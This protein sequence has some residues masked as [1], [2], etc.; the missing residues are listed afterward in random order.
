M[1]YRRTGA[2]GQLLPMAE[3][4]EAI[5]TDLV[6]P[7]GMAS[8]QLLMG[9]SHHLLGNQ[10]LARPHLQAALA[11]PASS[12][13]LSISRFGF[14]PDRARVALARTLWLAGFPDQA[15]RLATQAIDSPAAPQ[16][17]VTRCIVL[18]FGLSVF[19]WAGDLD[20]AELLVDE[21]AAHASRHSLAPFITVA[22]CL[23]GEMLIKRG[24][25]ERGADLLQN[26][27][28]SL[29]IERYELYSTGFYTTLAEALR[30]TGQLGPALRI[31]DDAIG[32]ARSN[33]DLFYTPELMRIRADI[34]VRMADEQ[35]AEE[36]LG[37][38]L[39][40]AEAQSALSWR[41]R[42]AMSFAQL[43]L[44]QG[45]GPEARELLAET[46]GR[47]S[48]GFATDDLMTA[49]RLLRDIG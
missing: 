4:A 21:I 6:D 31:V 40:L 32:E 9:L 3:R 47:F 48:E 2:L 22:D 27:L 10:G 5:A 33:A 36:Q 8:A 16:D 13:P 49:K 38:A 37:Q 26:L 20:R 7:P 14:H 46:Y 12:I 1:Y 42:A 30:T 23:K 41:L 34:L 18:V 19:Q 44:Q 45:R 29:R 39:E 24:D 28:S 35:G 11:L 15:I 25:I 43:K 17:P